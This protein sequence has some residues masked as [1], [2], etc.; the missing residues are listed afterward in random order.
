MILIPADFESALSG[1]RQAVN[2]GE[3][4]EARIDESVLRILREKEKL[5]L[6]D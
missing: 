5:G 4:S 6:L 2:S 3:I 1:L